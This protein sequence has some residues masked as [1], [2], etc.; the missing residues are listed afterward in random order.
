MR[1]VFCGKY[2]SFLKASTIFKSGRHEKTLEMEY[3]NYYSELTN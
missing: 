1:K 2:T 3:K